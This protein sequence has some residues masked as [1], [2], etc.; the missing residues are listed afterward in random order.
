MGMKI[1][2]MPMTCLPAWVDREHN[3]AEK[4]CKAIMA[5]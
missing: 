4:V 2:G 1:Y 5:S 3:L